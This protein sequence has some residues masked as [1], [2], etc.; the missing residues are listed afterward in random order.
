MRVLPGILKQASFVGT[1]L[2]GAVLTQTAREATAQEKPTTGTSSP[3]LKASGGYT[4]TINR[5]DGTK[6]VKEF[7]STNFLFKQTTTKL[8]E[9]DTV[10]ETTVE[11]F[12]KETV[13][14]LKEISK[15]HKNGLS[16]RHE[17]FV[18][19]VLRRAKSITRYENKKLKEDSF[20]NYDINGILS[21]KSVTKYSEDSKKIDTE[22][23]D[24]F[25]RPTLKESLIFFKEDEY[26]WEKSFYNNGILTRKWVSNGLNQTKFKDEP[27]NDANPRLKKK[28]D[29]LINEVCKSYDAKG[30]YEGK[31]ITKRSTD[32]LIEI[33]ELTMPQIKSMGGLLIPRSTEKTRFQKNIA[34]NL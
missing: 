24:G 29:I 23:T 4:A 34:K 11:N 10:T 5:P 17:S 6:I 1:L 9:R 22:S 3:T 32:N 31:K 27:P 30:I 21:R 26:L 15:V 8:L 19:G 25:G 16:E 13:F 14:S 20:E 28:A 33:E 18:N 12:Q 2:T 7:D